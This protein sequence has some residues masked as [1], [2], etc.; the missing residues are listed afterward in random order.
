MQIGKTKARKQAELNEEDLVMELMVKWGSFPSSDP[1]E[2]TVVV[3]M[4]QGMRVTVFG[5]WGRGHQRL[6]E[7]R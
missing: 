5:C 3:A 2:G 4:S 7:R 6:T 1:D